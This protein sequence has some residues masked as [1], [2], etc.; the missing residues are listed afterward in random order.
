VRLADAAGLAVRYNGLRRYLA[1]LHCAGVGKV[2]LIRQF[3]D[4]Q[5]V[6]ASA[7]VDWALNEPHELRLEVRG[8]HA[9]AMADGAKLFEA[10]FDGLGAGPSS[11]LRT[12]GIACLADT[13][14]ASFADLS[15]TPL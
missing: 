6:L 14:T 9:A 7:E 10:E 3:D 5:Q 2:E 13:G 11:G 1:L 8:Q 12:G 4:T 15:V